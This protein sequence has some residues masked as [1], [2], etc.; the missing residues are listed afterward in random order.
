MGEDVE[1]YSTSA[2]QWIPARILG[3][4]SDGTC[5]LD[6]KKSAQR[7]NIRRKALR[8]SIDCARNGPQSVRQQAKEAV[9][10]LSSDVSI[11]QYFNSAAAELEDDVFSGRWAERDQDADYP[12]AAAPPQADWAD[13]GAGWALPPVAAS[14]GRRHDR[15]LP[16]VFPDGRTAAAAAEALRNLRRAETAERSAASYKEM[17]EMAE[18]RVLRAETACAQLRQVGGRGRKNQ[19]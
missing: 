11:Q 19:V 7:T 12:P 18:T 4:N 5:I 2:A 9:V 1:Y 16:A 13:G 8:S 3:F 10:Q 6:V 15:L 14:A 17:L